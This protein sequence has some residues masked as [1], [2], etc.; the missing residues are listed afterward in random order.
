MTTLFAH[1]V[2]P[3]WFLLFSHSHPILCS[4]NKKLFIYGKYT[5]FL[6]CTSIDSYNEYCKE[7]AH[8]FKRSNHHHHPD[9]R[10]K[11]PSD[12]TPRKMLSKLNSLKM[13]S[14]R[15]LSIQ[16]PD[17]AMGPPEELPEGEMP[18]SDSTYSID[19]P[20]SITLWEVTPRPNES[21]EYYNFTL[22]AMRLNEFEEGMQVP[23][24]LA[25][26]DSR[27]RPDIRKLENGDMEGAAAE[28]TRLEEAQ[29]D[30]DKKKKKS[31]TIADFVPRWFQ[32][33][34]NAYTKSEDWVYKG[35]YWERDYKDVDRD[36]F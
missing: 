24:T 35:G 4:K 19:I 28:K 1:H 32:Q 29:R 17:D 7:N 8:K 9:D 30:R 23:R 36:I 22:F 5:E 27:L 34:Q 12:H 18:K 10:S 31:T 25:P 26:T 2:L 15:S 3:P 6:K 21:S 16:E 13:S 11:S 20:D 33:T 14:F